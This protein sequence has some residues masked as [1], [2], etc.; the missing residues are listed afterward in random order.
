M[1]IDLFHKSSEDCSRRIALNY[2]TSFSLGIRMLAVDVRP[3]VFNIYGIVRVA[4]E[5]VDTMHEFDKETLLKDFKRETYL[6][7]EKGISTN[8]ILNSFQ[9]TANKYNIGKEL[10]E[11]FF[12]SM[13]ED[14]ETNVHNSDSYSEYIYGSA[15]VVGLMCLKVF[16]NGDQ[17]SYQELMPYAKSLGA[18]FQKVNFLRDIKSDLEERGRSYFPDVNFDLFTE[19]DK[20]FIVEDIKEDFNHALIGIKMLPQGCKKGVYT[21]YVY[22]LELLEKIE[23]TQAPQILNER[24]RIP[25][26]RKML[27]LAKSYF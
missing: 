16:C 4:D 1:S 22:Y 13:E 10:I 18:A 26:Y 9:R 5:I 25:N 15:E 19:A 17:G 2:S 3:D 6:A 11:P 27:L 24:I 14:L 7:I 8:P 21:A 12:N 20:D 23:K